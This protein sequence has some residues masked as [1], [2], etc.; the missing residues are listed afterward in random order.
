MPNV[1]KVL[2]QDVLLFKE[3]NQLA[4]TCQQLKSSQHSIQRLKSSRMCAR[5]VVANMADVS[6]PKMGKTML[7]DVL[8]DLVAVFAKKVCL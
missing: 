8:Q 7:A 2:F 1:S 6:H 5:T 4:R 3:K